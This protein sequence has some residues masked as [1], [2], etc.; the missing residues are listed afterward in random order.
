[1][2]GKA[3]GLCRRERELT[4]EVWQR[5]Q[6]RPNALVDL[7]AGLRRQ[8]GALLDQRERGLGLQLAGA[9]QS[10]RLVEPSTELEQRISHAH[11]TIERVMGRAQ[12][13]GRPGP[14]PR[15]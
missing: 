2:A 13:P 7:G 1:M 14:G 10:R 11:K 3:R 9:Q 8:L 6:R 5:L 4:G 15:A 12:T